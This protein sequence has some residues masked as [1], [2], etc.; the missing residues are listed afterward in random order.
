[1]GFE[2]ATTD[3]IDRRWT[4]I[5]VVDSAAAIRGTVRALTANPTNIAEWNSTSRNLIFIPS[6]T[7]ITTVNAKSGDR[8][9]L[10]IGGGNNTAG[11]TP[12]FQLRVGE[13]GTDAVEN[14]TDITDSPGWIEFSV[15]LVFTPIRM[16]RFNSPYGSYF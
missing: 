6:G 13:A 1:M 5:F 4:K 3:N 14:E 10:E 12:Q 9:V 16:A 15:N 7:A 2:V 11:T 8:I